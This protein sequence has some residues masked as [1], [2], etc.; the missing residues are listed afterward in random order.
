MLQI[1]VESHITQTQTRLVHKVQHV[2]FQPLSLLRCLL[3]LLHSISTKLDK[4]IEKLE[5]CPK[6]SYIV[7]PNAK[8]NYS[9]KKHT[10]VLDLDETLVH[11]KTRHLE[12]DCSRSLSTRCDF[13]FEV[14]IDSGSATRSPKFCEY[15]VSQRPHLDFFLQ[16]VGKWFNVVVFT[17]S[18]QQYADPLIDH[19]DHNNVISRRFYRQHCTQLPN[20]KFSKNLSF[21]QQDLS[22]VILLDNSSCSFTTNPENAFPISDWFE[23]P[24]DEELIDCLPILAA[25]CDVKDVRN[26]LRLRL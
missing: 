12:R 14:M 5:L 18:L 3:W 20:G 16:H 21:V 22:S 23:D 17:A 13:S 4:H 26:I 9:S 19:L 6:H 1:A 24:N 8:G 7:S 15:F 11:T 25:L 10:L 2:L